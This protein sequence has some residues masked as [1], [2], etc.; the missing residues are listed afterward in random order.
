MADTARQTTGCF[1]GRR[2]KGELSLEQLNTLR[3]GPGRIITAK[4]YMR[5]IRLFIEGMTV[6]EVAEMEGVRPASIYPALNRIKDVAFL[7]GW[8]IE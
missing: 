6:S 7:H 2:Y 1:V 5:G 4:D 8:H 3:E